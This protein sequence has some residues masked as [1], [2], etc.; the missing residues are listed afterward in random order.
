MAG[1]KVV[2]NK[3]IRM[4]MT[5]VC[6]ATRRA[7]FPGFFFITEKDSFNGCIMETMKLGDI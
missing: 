5:R 4:I 7:I 6:K 3:V 1:T 2:N